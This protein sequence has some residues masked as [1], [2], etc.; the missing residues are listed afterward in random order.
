MV[1]NETRKNFRMVG[2]WTDR[3]A[4][5]TPHNNVRWTM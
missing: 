4:I 1:I 5:F 3:K 2:I